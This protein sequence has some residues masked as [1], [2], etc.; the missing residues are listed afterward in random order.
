MPNTFQQLKSLYLHLYCN[1]EFL[2]RSFRS[3]DGF[4]TL[5]K[6]KLS[7]CFNFEEFPEMKRGVMPKLQTLNLMSCEFKKS[8][9]LFLKVFNSLRTLKLFECEDSFQDCCKRNCEKSLI[10]RRFRIHFHE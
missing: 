10:W 1:L 3:H 4:P 7:F 2:P 9:H 8:L 6:F 5:L